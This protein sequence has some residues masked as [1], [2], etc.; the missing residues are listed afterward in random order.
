MKRYLTG[1]YRTFEGYEFR[2]FRNGKKKFGE[3]VAR[4]RNDG[5]GMNCLL[6]YEECPENTTSREP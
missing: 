5:N 6:I 2:P 1:T 4:K 3:V